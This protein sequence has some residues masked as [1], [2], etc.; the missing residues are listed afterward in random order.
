MGG[1]VRVAFGALQVE[2]QST[3]GDTCA[4]RS[5][6]FKLRVS[7]LGVSCRVT[8]RPSST[9]RS[10]V[11]REVIIAVALLRRHLHHLLLQ[12]PLHLPTIGVLM[13]LTGKLWCERAIE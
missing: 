6:L 13:R 10:T 8:L 2:S 9:T 7:V 5:V 11:M 1:Y 3:W 12:R 4:W